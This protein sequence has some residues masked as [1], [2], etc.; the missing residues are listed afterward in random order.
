MLKGWE[1]SRGSK[2]LEIGANVG[3]YTAYCANLGARVVAYEADPATFQVLIKNL[4]DQQLVAKTINKAVWI[5]NGAC[6]FRGFTRE[7]TGDHNGALAHIRCPDNG[8]F[9][10]PENIPCVSFNDAVGSQEWDCVKVDIEGSEFEMLLSASDEALRQIKFMYV[11]FH[12]WW[13]DPELP[14][15]LINRLSPFFAIDGLPD[16]A[17]LRR[18]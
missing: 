3:I 1:P 18:H 17:C 12:P 9:R 2:V 10:K 11:E 16:Y 4:A 13:V 6:T 15:K 14:G 7:E 8:L 5:Y